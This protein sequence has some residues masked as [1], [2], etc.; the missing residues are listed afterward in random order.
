MTGER[1]GWFA[2]LFR[3]GHARGEFDGRHVR[4]ILEAYGA[5]LA[6][7]APERP[8]RSER[9]LPYSKEEIG[10]SI[11]IALKFAT[12]REAVEPL[13]RSFA[14]L[15]RFLAG[16]EWALIDEYERLAAVG[17]LGGGMT[18]TRRAEAVRLLAEIEARRGR[19]FEL[20]SILERERN[21]PR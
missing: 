21:P 15:E 2:R 7:R 20:L 8:H 3:R 19:R 14:E 9:E 13:R 18:E 4:V 5:C 1:R 17:G 12:T 11:L 10:R 6:R 16:D